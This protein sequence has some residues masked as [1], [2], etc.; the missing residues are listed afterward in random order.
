MKVVQFPASRVKNQ[1]TGAT[2]TR[3]ILSVVGQTPSSFIPTSFGLNAW[4]AIFLEVARTLNTR[5]SCS[6]DSEG[7]KSKN[8]SLYVVK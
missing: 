1:S 2:P 7:K 4:A 6:T 5:L 8:F 3:V